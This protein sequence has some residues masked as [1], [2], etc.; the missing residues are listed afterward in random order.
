MGK[1][2]TFVHSSL[3][4]F[5]FF[6]LGPN[7][8]PS[9]VWG[10]NSSSTSIF[11]QWGNVPAADQNGVIISYTVIYKA[12]PDGSPQTKL[13]SAPTTHVTLTDL[14]EYTNYSITVFASTIM[15]NGNLSEPIVIITDE[16]SK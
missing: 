8:P 6:S 7:A 12:L 1:Y 14:N 15:G 11:V 3:H 9:N 16:D 4:S 10:Q 13:V 2:V 5:C